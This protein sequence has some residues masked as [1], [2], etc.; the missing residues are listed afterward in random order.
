MTL[1]RKTLL[2]LATASAVS[3]LLSYVVLRGTVYTT[4]LELENNWAVNNTERVEAAIQSHVDGLV[5]LNIEYSQ[6]DDFYLYM[7]DRD[8]DFINSN[9]DAE[10]LQ[11]LDLD[12]VT[13][14]DTQGQLVY[15]IEQ[16][17]DYG[18]AFQR[19][20]VFTERDAIHDLISASRATESELV[21]FVDNQLGPLLLISLPVLRNDAQGPPA[22]SLLFGQFLTEERIQRLSD[23]LSIDF[24]VIPISS[25]RLAS[26]FR[27]ALE[28]LDNTS[29]ELPQTR[30]PGR[31]L[32]YRAIRDIFDE[33]ALV[34]E[35]A[36][37]R[38]ISHVGTQAV[39]IA[40]AFLAATS[41][42]Y[43]L[44][45]TLSLKRLIINPVSDL[46]H[47][48]G[49]IQKSG[50]LSRRIS[51][52]RNDEMG[53]LTNRV[54]S[55]VEALDTAQNE[56]AATRDKALE[57]SKA[58]SQFLAN[59]SHEI[60]TPINGVLG[61]TELLLNSTKL[62]EQ[63]R[64]YAKMVRQSGDS[65]L[66]I[67]N[68][69]LDVSKIEAGK[70]ELDIAP[71]NLRNVVEESLELLAERA[72]A[73]GLE[74]AGDIA[75][76]THTYVQGDPVRLRQIL[77]N[78]IGN[79]VKFT[80]QGEIIVR[81]T[82][83]EDASD[84]T[85]Y[86]FEVQDTGVGI[87]PEK[88]NAIFESFSQEDGSTTRRFGGTGL[89]L[90]ISKQL[91]DLM[92]GEIGVDST[93]GK[94]STFWFTAHLAKDEA[95][96]SYLQP[97]V[98][99]GTRVLIVDDNATNREILRHQLEGWRVQVVEASSG[100]EAL[101]RLSQTSNADEP[102]DVVL[103][104]MHMPEMDGLE[105]ARV[106]RQDPDFGH[107]SLVML[108]S[109]STAGSD[110]ER[111]EAG[112]DAWLTKPI[113]QTR[114]HE[115]L[116][117]VMASEIL[118]RTSDGIQARLRESEIDG[119]EISLRILLV[120]D[121][122]VNLAVAEGMLSALGHHTTSARNG[123]EAVLAFQAETFDLVLMDCQMPEM[124]GFEATQA[125]RQWEKDKHR[126]PTRIIALT[127]NALKGDRERCLKA[128]MDDYLSK[129]FTTEQLRDVSTSHMPDGRSILREGPHI[130]SINR[131][132]L[133]EIRELDPD[134]VDDLLREIV[135]T[136]CASS[137][138]LLVQ[139]RSAISEGDA[140]A[141]GHIAHSLKGASSQIGATLLA[142][143][144]E[145]LVSAARN[146]NLRNA[147]TLVEQAAI[148]HFA[149]IDA[150]DKEVQSAAA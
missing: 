21:G 30:E 86:R 2:V 3:I 51:S 4:F 48:V 144:C 41:I 136:F 120:E 82:E 27:R 22:G 58:K 75:H 125:I 119:N 118:K 60:R 16:D 57:A 100:S 1:I 32:N 107:L 135:V 20:H 45:S 115:A 113:R 87:N 43:L 150:L 5:L 70:L 131:Q 74:L 77:V 141:V 88:T 129:P 143:L 64:R 59:M 14:L 35:V 36:A 68:D 8:E 55:L 96:S 83:R 19:T 85:V 50:D 137:T 140:D 69:I 10:I 149:V 110:L 122:S 145:H 18:T 56:M 52:T 84:T 72:H 42:L 104:D 109:V 23:Q 29:T 25:K 17:S 7:H 112:L 99:A 108:S 138:K 13:V 91:I 93:P 11:R 128:G 101:A 139:L 90:S 47:H 26:D 9:I 146:D 54:G 71:F 46:T 92:G 111:Q 142:S 95:T 31:V 78:L 148:E 66:S 80:E 53:T 134:N 121:N 105:V 123:C 15:G 63:Q 37:E 76:S 39:N 73:K 114:L 133:E 117:S 24:D 67:I 34:L 97:D 79:A 38:E 147:S 33:P 12:F 124:D 126:S 6:W 106:I 49:R 132:S 89:G 65:L 61:M 44:V 98:L 81:L 116:Q 127:A 102:F 94:G 130:A 103:L 28:S 40:L 62:D